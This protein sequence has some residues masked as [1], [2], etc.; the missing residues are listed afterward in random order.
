MHIQLPDA[1]L[2]PIIF[3]KNLIKKPGKGNAEFETQIPV[4]IDSSWGSLNCICRN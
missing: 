1:T 3:L 2:K 4:K